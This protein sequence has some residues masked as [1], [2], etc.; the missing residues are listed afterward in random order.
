[1]SKRFNSKF[2][3]VAALAAGGMTAAQAEGA[4]V[5]GSLGVPN[6]SSTIGGIGGDDGGAA[7]K[8]FGGYQL[9]PNLGFEGGYVDLG[10]T[11]SAGGRAKARGVFGDVVGKVMVAPSLSVLGSAGLA[12]V[13]FSTPNGT[14]WSPALKLG[15]GLQYDVTAQTAVTLQYDRYR[16]TNAFGSKPYVGALTAGVKFGF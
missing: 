1:M 13:R 4:Y 11:D 8:L 3:V 16:F 15:A 10:H 6:F 5:G 14:D 2:F 9:T 12:D 7:G